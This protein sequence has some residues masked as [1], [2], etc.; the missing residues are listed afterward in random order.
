MMNDTAFSTLGHWVNDFIAKYPYVAIILTSPIIF[1]IT[2]SLLHPH[3]VPGKPNAILFL[4]SDSPYPQPRASTLSFTSHIRARID[5]TIHAFKRGTTPWGLSK[6]I[7]YDHQIDWANG[8]RP[9]NGDLIYAWD[10]VFEWNEDCIDMAAL[11]AMR[12]LGDP[13]SENVLDTLS[14]Q[15]KEQAKSHDTM[16]RVATHILHNQTEEEDNVSQ[17]WK[18]VSRRPPVGCG[19]LSLQW[20]LKND[21][22]TQEEVNRMG[23]GKADI[24]LTDEPSWTPKTDEMIESRWSKEQIQTIRQ[25]EANVLQRARTAFHRY[26]PN[27]SV[28]LLLVGLAGG[29]ASP[30]IV[31]VLKSTGYLVA[32]RKKRKVEDKEE[33]ALLQRLHEYV[34]KGRNDIQDRL[35][36]TQKTNITSQVLGKLDVPSPATSDRTY[37]RLL[38]TMTFLLDLNE[39]PESLVPPSPHISSKD[40]EIMSAQDLLNT[41]GKGW[42]ACCRVRFL[43]TSVRKRLHG[44]TGEDG[45]YSSAK[46]GLAINQEDLLATLC[47]FSVAPLWALQRLGL[48]PTQQERQDI[49]AFWRHVGFYMGI[50]PRL[51]RRHFRDVHSAER[52]FSCISSHH[53]LPFAGLTDSSST[54]PPSIPSAFG[55]SLMH[56]ANKEVQ[57]SSELLQ[58]MA[59]LASRFDFDQG[60]ALPLLWSVA[61]R[62]PGKMTFATLCAIA[63][64]LLGP[65]L[66]NATSLPRTTTMQY[67][68]MRFRLFVLAYPVVF[69]T[70]YARR[71]WSVELRTMWVELIRRVV[72][73]CSQGKRTSFATSRDGT[74]DDTYS[75]YVLDPNAGKRIM[76]NYWRIMSEMIFVS[77]VAGLIVVGV[78]AYALHLSIF[79]VRSHGQEALHL[80]TSHSHQFVQHYA[81]ALFAHLS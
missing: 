75:P 24:R 64:F 74:H 57:M 54:P 40:K 67:L 1:A 33:D 62:P 3:L 46:S 23:Y 34:E 71:S 18:A 55:P 16:E 14:N 10:R 66:A 19:A 53:F 50:E 76:K 78:F 44:S 4:F 49:C 29:F 39:T 13:I 56:D 2:Y 7:R 38:E 41:G 25:E 30:R 9:K 59:D 68:T 81:P 28:G 69:G 73:W 20:Y 21:L 5:W 43:H 58:S 31:D 26:G 42:L 65:G 77:M 47:A 36:K 51:L 8:E 45:T 22:L 11:E 37:R 6:Q 48:T 61:N 63:R 17:F 12:N 27:M 35:A 80:L 15:P 72:V 52:T 70:Y 32:P 60:P 79:L